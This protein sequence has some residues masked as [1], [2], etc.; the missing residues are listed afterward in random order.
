MGK[1]SC[2]SKCVCPKRVRKTRK[3]E[4]EYPVDVVTGMLLAF[5]KKM[6]RRKTII[7]LTFMS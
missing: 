2:I 3:L 4:R 6:E 5:A 7:D 1:F